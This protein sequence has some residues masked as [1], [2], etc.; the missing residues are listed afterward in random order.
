MPKK[1]KGLKIVKS[2]KRAPPKDKSWRLPPKKRLSWKMRGRIET[3]ETR[4][5]NRNKKD[6]LCGC[7]CGKMMRSDKIHIHM[8]KKELKKPNLSSSRKEEILKSLPKL[9]RCDN[10]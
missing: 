9:K 6:L 4:K 5:A 2:A 8:L 10:F 3:N 1:V 7:G